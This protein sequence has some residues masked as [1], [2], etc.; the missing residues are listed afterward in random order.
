MAVEVSIDHSG[1]VES[2]LLR[3][4]GLVRSRSVHGMAPMRQLYSNPITVSG[5]GHTRK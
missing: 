1:G 2:P 4:R 3:T 5:S